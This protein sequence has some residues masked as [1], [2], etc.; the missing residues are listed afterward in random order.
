[1]YRLPTPLEV[2]QRIEQ[3]GDT[4]HPTENRRVA[5]D[6]DDMDP[7]HKCPKCGYCDCFRPITDEDAKS[8]LSQDAQQGTLRKTTFNRWKWVDP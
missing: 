1:M 4:I 8:W 2:R 3:V 5:K 7:P 6:I